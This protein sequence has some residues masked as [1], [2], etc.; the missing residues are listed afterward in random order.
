MAMVVKNNMSALNTLNTLN[1]NT[2]AL[3]KSLQKVSS[4]MKINSAAD[5]ASGYAISEN[6]RA[7]IRTLDQANTNTQNASSLMKIA[8]G[9][10]NNAVD[11]LKTM[12]EKA[13]NAAN[14]HNT[15]SDRAMMQK[16]LDQLADQLNDNANVT[17]N[18]K[19]IF[20]GSLNKT[21]TKEQTAI[22]A[23]NSEWLAAS[24]DLIEQS[25]GLSFTGIYSQTNQMTVK[26]GDLGT[27]DTLAF[28]WPD[29]NDLTMVV[30]TKALENWDGVNTDGHNGSWYMDR[31]IV[32][33]MIHA[34]MAA[35]GMSVGNNTWDT[36]LVEGA[37]EV[38][39]GIDDKRKDEIAKA[40]TGAGTGT[41]AYADGYV[42]YRY[43]IQNG[44]RSA[45]DTMKLF[46]ETAAQTNSQDKAVEAVT[47]GRFTKWSDLNTYLKTEL[48]TFNAYKLKSMTG[49]DLDNLD[50]G[51]II[52]L[53]ASGHGTQTASDIVLEGG[54]AKRWTN[55]TSDK[56]IINGLEVTWDHTLYTINDKTRPPT[57][58]A[59]GTIPGLSGGFSFQVGTRASQTINTAMAYIDA[60][61]LGIQ[62]DDGSNV[63][64]STKWHAVQA[65]DLIERSVNH[66]L[67]LATN[68]GAVMNRL[69]YTSSNLVTESENVT[70]A[71]STIRD[72][73]M[74]KEM[75]EYT[76][77]NVLMQA[78]QSM[79]SQA[80]QNSSNAL[81][82][83]Q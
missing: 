66:A 39:H 73:D 30:N 47:N 40:Y 8:D 64:I 7:Q 35:N 51:S 5:D 28:V 12:K 55:P 54:S 82:L 70:A 18:G 69:E 52:G 10:L 58:T 37:A 62:A 36:V 60:K 15:D 29:A 16:E 46:M 42:A 1:T 22:A 61:G 17:F 32:H 23:L 56:T 72:A 34:V 43:M 81:G 67:D 78:A 2:T 31:T 25:T 50:T 83:L 33:E 49:I 19:Y 38:I 14:D 21:E 3:S 63:N 9:A 13:I 79:L 6:M 48:G 57:Y 65:I 59:A 24:L 41:K 45:V 80:N 68:V 26:I 75:T 76:K 53:D 20:D 71:E 44:G 77:N 27:A 11:I 4:G 74:A